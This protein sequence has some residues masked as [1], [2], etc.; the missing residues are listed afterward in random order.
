MSVIYPYV[1]LELCKA[2]IER[3]GYTG[4]IE[5]GMDVAASG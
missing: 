5:I 4:K 1:G 2:A 3:A